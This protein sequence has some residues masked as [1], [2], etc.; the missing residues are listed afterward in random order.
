[1]INLLL[2]KWIERQGSLSLTQWSDRFRSTEKPIR[3]ERDRFFI[4]FKAILRHDGE[5]NRIKMTEF[6]E[7]KQELLGVQEDVSLKDYTTFNI[8]GPARYFL[9]EAASRG[10]FQSRRQMAAEQLSGPA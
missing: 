7:I 3:L 6:K 8:G 1:M 9:Q 5:C 10:F 4:D 2:Y